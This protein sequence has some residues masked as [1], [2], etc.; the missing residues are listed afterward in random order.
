ME[1]NEFKMNKKE[2]RE[3]AEVM[4]ELGFDWVVVGGERDDL[5]EI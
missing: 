1:I 5:L 4:K 3:I 2:T